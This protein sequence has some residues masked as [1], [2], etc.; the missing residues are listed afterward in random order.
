MLLNIDKPLRTATL[1]QED[2]SRIPQPVGTVHKPVGQL[3][4]DG[5]WFHV[6]DRAGA[7]MLAGEQFA[8]AV[9]IR[10]QYC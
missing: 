8:R 9:F 10:C 5:G 1:H 7:E 3:G 2:C 4:R 6:D